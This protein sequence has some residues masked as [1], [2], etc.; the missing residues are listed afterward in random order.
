MLRN[1]IVL[2]PLRCPFL[3]WREEYVGL[4]CYFA[5]IHRTATNNSHVEW[6][7]FEAVKFSGTRDAWCCATHTKTANL[8]TPR[9]KAAHTVIWT[10]GLH[11]YSKV[12]QDEHRGEV[13]HIQEEVR[14]SSRSR[15]KLAYRILVHVHVFANGYHAKTTRP[16]FWYLGFHSFRFGIRMCK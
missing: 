4:G 7:I 13:E 14:E 1:H 3:F 10:P 6:S 2:P 9:G 11:R 12:K 8:Y 16:A 15:R 5:I